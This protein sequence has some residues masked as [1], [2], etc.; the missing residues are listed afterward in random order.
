MMKLRSYLVKL[1]CKPERMDTAQQT[2]K[3]NK[4]GKIEAQQSGRAVSNECILIAS[5]SVEIIKTHQANEQK[6]SCCQSPQIRV[7]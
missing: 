3:G 4:V 5:I 7:P 2:T 1:S 6:E